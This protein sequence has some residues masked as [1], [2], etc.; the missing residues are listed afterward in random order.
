MTSIAT[1]IAISILP[2]SARAQ[3]PEP[4]TRVSVLERA[5][6]EKATRLTPHVPNKAEKYLDY[7]E[8]VLTTGMH[9]HPFFDSAYSGGGFTLGAGY[10]NYVSSYN[11][12]DVRGSITFSGYKRIEGEF[13]APGCSIGAAPSARLPGG[14]RT[15][16]SPASRAAR[17][18]RDWPAPRRFP[19]TGA[20]SRMPSGSCGSR[21]T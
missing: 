2:S 19:A 20:P 5:Q 9:F 17:L 16:T 3:D 14:A 11:T 6:A 10:R 12:V 8:S 21:A 15:T 13:L 4:A 7:A 18:P 1:L